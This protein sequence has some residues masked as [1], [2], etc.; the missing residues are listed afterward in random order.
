MQ[1]RIFK[2][3]TRIQYISTNVA[4]KEAEPGGDNQQHIMQY[5]Y[6]YR[7][8]DTLT[9]SQMNQFQRTKP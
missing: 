2:V 4:N 5:V 6:D 7:D 8:D 1:Y 3:V 9:E